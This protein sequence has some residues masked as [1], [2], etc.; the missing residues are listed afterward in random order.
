MKFR[1]ENWSKYG[2]FFLGIISL[3]LLSCSSKKNNNSSGHAVKP[4]VIVSSDIGGTDPD[5]FQSMIHFLMYADKFQV[6]GIIASPYGKGR[7][8]DILHIIDLYAKDYPKLKKHGDFPSPNQLRLVAKQGATDGN[9]A[10]GWGEPSEGSKWIIKQAKS[11]NPQPLWILCWGGLDDVAQALHDAPSIASKI[12]VYWIGG[13]NKKWSVSPYQ[14]IARNFPNLWMIE[15]NSTYRGWII[16]N[17]ANPDLKPKAFYEKYI[18]GKGALGS[19]FGNYYGGS[20]KMGDSPSVAYL[21]NG[22][23]DNPAGQSWGGSF[24]K[25][26]YSAF[27]NFNQNTT[28][29]DTVPT[30]SV[31]TWTFDSKENIAANENPEIWMEIDGQRINGFYA[32]NGVFKVRFVPKRIGNWKYTVNCSVKS[33]QGQTGEFVSANP[34]PGAENPDNAKL[35]NW[36]SDRTDKDLYVEQYQGTETIAKWRKDFLM[37]W[38]KRFE[39]IAN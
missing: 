21:L 30:Y 28:T 20:I 24:T 22:N 31:V 35:N 36:W 13:P 8:T 32:G 2:L 12:R 25:L 19:D 23:P 38:A 3:S 7:K 18:K 17:S 6:D 14:Y 11:D 39:W 9:P 16:D 33:L 37:D 15:N 27:R 1:I 10:K 34:W 26:P 4:R 5:D 29:T